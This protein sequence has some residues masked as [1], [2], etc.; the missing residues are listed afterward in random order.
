MIQAEADRV[1]VLIALL[2]NA[3]AELLRYR[4]L[5][6]YIPGYVTLVQL[7]VAG[8]W[9]FQAKLPYYYA[10]Y[11]AILSQ[12]FVILVGIAGTWFLCYVH[13]RLNRE[14]NRYATLLARLAL[15]EVRVEGEERDPYQFGENKGPASDLLLPRRRL[16]RFVEPGWGS[17]FVFSFIAY[18]VVVTAFAILILR[19]K[20]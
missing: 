17:A 7:G 8:G 2:R 4:N 13:N 12:V 3:E 19:H 20:V 6:W 5:E 16:I 11:Y 14:R 9:P 15:D 18:I 1:D 10:I